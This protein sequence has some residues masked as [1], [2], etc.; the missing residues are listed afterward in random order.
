MVGA[1]HSLTW[2]WPGGQVVTWQA[3]MAVYTVVGGGP[4][5]ELVAAA[6]S[7]PEPP[8]PSWSQRLRHACRRLVSDLAGR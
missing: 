1:K 3:G 6:A 8:A 7:V 5:S 2:A 4:L